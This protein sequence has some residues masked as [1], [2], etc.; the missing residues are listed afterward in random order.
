M[1]ASK[2]LKKDL[3]EKEV[4]RVKLSGELARVES[5]VKRERA[6][7]T[8]FKIQQSNPDM[9]Q[10]MVTHTH[11]HFIHMVLEQCTNVVY[12]CLFK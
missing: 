9:P 5:E 11:M 7:N 12:N 2:K 4:A 8:K 3:R 6:R 10:V 1:S